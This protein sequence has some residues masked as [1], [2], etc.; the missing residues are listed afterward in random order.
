MKILKVIFVSFF[1]LV[2]VLISG[3]IIFVKTF[4][5]NRYKPQIASQAGDVLNRKVDFEKARLVFSLR[6]GLGFMMSNFVIAEDPAFAKGDFL[7][8]KDISLSVDV[9]G[10]LFHKKVNISDILIDG[11]RVTIIRQK[12]GTRNVQGI[13]QPAGGKA[14]AQKPAGNAAPVALPALLISAIKG[15]RGE[16][17]YID[18]SFEPPME[19]VISDLDCMLSKISLTD[20]FPFTIEGRVLSAQKNIRI[21]GQAQLNLGAQE[22]TLSDLKGETDLSRILLEKIPSSFPMAKDVVL[23]KALSGMARI[24]LEKVTAG[25]KGLSAL[26]G[27]I[28]LDKVSVQLTQLALPIKDIQLR[29][30]VSLAKV[31][32]DTFSA[33]LGAGSIKGS[34]SIEDYLTTQ[35]FNVTADA[36]NI[37]IEDLVAQEKLPVKSTGLV[38][39]HIQ[40]T[41]KGFTPEA[42]TTSLSGTGQ[43]ALKKVTLKDINVFQTV[44]G[45]L[46]MIPGISERIAAAVPERYKQALAQKDTVLSDTELPIVIENGRV[47]I[48]D[49]AISSETFSFKGRVD[50]G[51]DTS[52]A[53]EGSFLVPADLSAG[54]VTGVPELQYLQNEDKQVFF[55]IKVAGKGATSALSVDAGY[56]AE[57]LVVNQAKTQLMQV[58]DKSIGNKAPGAAPSSNTQGVTDKINSILGNILKK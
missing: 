34:G 47:V 30:K 10:Y 33:S 36:D 57:K 26:T 44:I 1:V 9:L 51:F 27:D 13:A 24:G 48:K 46:S 8:I 52:Y 58:I 39:G 35:A 55:P 15:T 32:L 7:K 40:L 25:S 42:L 56:I 22:V 20:R 11:F 2:F 28:G 38:S 14:G 45:K 41:G 5:V 29:A 12:D 16:V 31:I 19:L 23:P 21:E 4:D 17:T 37:N 50:V 53:M 18:R 49:A 6:Q 54:L 3:L 43:I